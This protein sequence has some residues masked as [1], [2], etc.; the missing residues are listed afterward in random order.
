VAVKA[1]GLF[2]WAATACNFVANPSQ[3][4]GVNMQRRYALVLQSHGLDKLYEGILW[5]RL[6][7][8]D[9]EIQTVKSVL[10]RVLAAAEPLSVNV[11]KE[12]CLNKEEHDTVDNIIPFLGSVL[13]VHGASTIRP[14]HTSFRDYLTDRSRS[15]ALFIDIK[16]GHQDLCLAAFHIMRKELHFNISQM[17]SSYMRNMDLTEDQHSLISPA[18]FYSC[19]FWAEHLQ[20]MESSNGWDMLQHFMNHQVLFW[21]EVLSIKE[22]LSGAVSAMEV[23]LLVRTFLCKCFQ[24]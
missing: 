8:E 19:Q 7:T 6:P 15:Q 10:A 9:E 4:A 17:K 3:K 2:Q 14:I 11:L 1:D 23:V 21:L 18:L 22:A 24:N 12:L 20:W 13:T 5:E 16:H